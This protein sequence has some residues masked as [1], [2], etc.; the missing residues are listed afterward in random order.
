MPGYLTGEH[1][2]N[3]AVDVEPGRGEV[4][5]LD[6][7]I[8]LGKS[9]GVVTARV[10]D[11]SIGKYPVNAPDCILSTELPNSM[12]MLLSSLAH[13]IELA[14]RLRDCCFRAPLTRTA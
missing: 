4:I 3:T 10:N 6:F 5:N 7:V 14:A 12:M 11:P 8:G 13:G 9:A 1:R 2:N